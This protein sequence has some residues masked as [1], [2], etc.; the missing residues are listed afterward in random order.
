VGIDRTDAGRSSS[1]FRELYYWVDPKDSRGNFQAP[2]IIN[3][4]KMI[5]RQLILTDV[6]LSVRQPLV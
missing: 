3:Y 2:L 5:G 4:K 1:R 6:A